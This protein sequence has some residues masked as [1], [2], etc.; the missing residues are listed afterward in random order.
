MVT[1]KEILDTTKKPISEE[2]WFS[3]WIEISELFSPA[4]PVQEAQ[5]FAG[6]LN[7]LERLVAAVF[8]RGQHIIVYGE[9]GVGKT[10]LINTF[11]LK[12]FPKSSRVKFFSTGCFK[13]DDFVK[14]WER[15]MSDNQFPNG[16]YAFDEIDDTLTPDSLAKAITKFGHNIQPVF[17]FDEFDRIED[18][19]TKLR[20]AETIKLLSDWSAN[21]T[22]VIVGIGRTIQ[23]LL[24]EH[25][26]VKRAAKQIGMPRMK[27]EEQ[28][29]T[30]L[31]RLKRAGMSIQDEALDQIVILARGMP[32]YAHL[33]G[34]YSA[35]VA[36]HNRT[37]DI[38][39]EHLY[40]SLPICLEESGESTRQSYAKAVQSSKPNNQF[41]EVLLA[42]ALAEQDEFGGFTMAALRKPIKEILKEEKDIPAFSRHLNA[43]C[44]EKRGNILQKEGT[45]KN[46]KFHFVDP[47]MQSYIITRGLAEKSIKY[48]T[49]E[50]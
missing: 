16:D 32:G 2:D 1:P 31:V 13:G 42:C 26:S 44:Q 45:P 15:A 10:S 41:K 47:I 18:K 17:I 12:L 8:Q 11:K 27:P 30:V 33:L 7:Q 25:E 5:L 43:F 20:M 9:R 19:D 21:A 24:Y 6:R 35:K 29:E 49:A 28:K 40:E 38:T 3:K 39:E 14:I 46:Y 23:D 48:K 37:L 4:H 50:I 22:I 36:I 34:M